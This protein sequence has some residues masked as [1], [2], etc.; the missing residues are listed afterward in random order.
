MAVGAIANATEAEFDKYM[1][2]FRPFLSLGLSNYEEHQVCQVAVGV[3]GDICRALEGRLL[4][5]CD[6]ILGNPNP[7]P[8]PNPDPNP[9][10]NPNPEPEP[11]AEPNPDQGCC[12]RTC[13]ARSS[14]ATSSRPY[15]RASATSRSPSAAT[16]K[17]TWT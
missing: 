3:V 8:N 13:R 11:D 16:L 12:S 4:P 15:S 1:P 5:Y 7:N 6:E 2:H 17:S 9:N 10:P 14:T